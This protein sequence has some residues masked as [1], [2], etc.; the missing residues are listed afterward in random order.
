[1]SNCMFIILVFFFG[2]GKEMANFMQG[3]SDKIKQ[4]CSTL[5]CFK[6]IKT[7]KKSTKNDPWLKQQQQKQQNCQTSKKK[8]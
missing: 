6:G 5:Q 4:L 2:K 1:M 8:D 7:K 3:R